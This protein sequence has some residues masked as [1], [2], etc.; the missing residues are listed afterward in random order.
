LIAPLPSWVNVQL[1]RELVKS[2][3]ANENLNHVWR[4]QYGQPDAEPPRPDTAVVA[5]RDGEFGA[6][7][8]AADS[9]PPASAANDTAPGEASAGLPFVVNGHCASLGNYRAF[10]KRVS[11]MV[12]WYFGW[13]SPMTRRDRELLNKQFRWLNRSPGDGLLTLFIVSAV[14]IC[15]LLGS[16]GFA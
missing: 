14:L 10:P 11:G 7:I 8:S 1:T 16:A 2:A 5:K 12:T 15:I 13:T 3:H 4:D 6:E 9:N